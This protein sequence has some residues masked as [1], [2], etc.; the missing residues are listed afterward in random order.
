MKTTALLVAC[1]A[2]ARAGCV[3]VSTDRIVAGDLA[4]TVPLFQDLDPRTPVGFTPLPGTRRVI[5][6]RELTLMAERHGLQAPADALPA[7]VCVER[8]TAPLSRADLKTALVSA[9]GVAGAELNVLDFSSEPLPP[10]RLEFQRSGLNQPPRDAPEA[11]VIWRGSLIYDGGRSATV[12]ARV[13]ITVERTWFVATENIPA[14]VL[15]RSQQVKQTSGRRFPRLTPS[16]G[17]AGEIIGKIALRGIQ[18]GQPFLSSGLAGPLEVQRGDKIH[19]RALDGL[20]ELSFDAIAESSGKKGAVI[21]VRN[22]SS[23]RNFR[24]VIEDKGQAV[25]RSF[26]GM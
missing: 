25:V 19:V 3:A 17:S 11:P 13:R 1:T 6:A 16:I 20:A 24:A 9:L 7:G 12:W 2:L 21:Q 4:A 15:I 10:G 18:A 5:S 26:P 8:A 23:G 14:G 22:P